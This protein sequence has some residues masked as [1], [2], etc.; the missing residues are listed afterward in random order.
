M[1]QRPLLR[2]FVMPGCLKNQQYVVRV[3]FDRQRQ[4]GILGRSTIVWTSIAVLSER[5]GHDLLLGRFSSPRI[6]HHVAGRLALF[7]PALPTTRRVTTLRSEGVRQRRC[8]WFRKRY[9][10]FD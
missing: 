3:V 2:P 4:L 10:D 9:V 8:R 6:V 5:T 1:A 7:V